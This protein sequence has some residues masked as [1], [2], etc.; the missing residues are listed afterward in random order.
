MKYFQLLFTPTK[1]RRFNELVGFVCFVVAALLFLALATYSPLDPSF[2]T[3]APGPSIRS[4]HNWIGMVGA[5]VSDLLLQFFGIVIFGVPV[6]L[7]M[8][9]IRW[10][11]SREISSPIAKSI[12][13]SLLFVFSSALLSLLPFHWRWLR[14]VAIEGLLGRIVGDFFV[15]YFNTLGAFMLCAT[16]VAIALY[17]STAFSFGTLQLW[18]VIGNASTAEANVQVLRRLSMRPQP[19]SRTSIL[20]VFSPLSRPISAR[21]ALAMPSTIVS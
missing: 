19:A 21:G 8:F 7:T 20:P 16:I 10:W 2:N 6:V 4:P 14:A 3:A 17:L 15:H 9:G 13:A 5:L 11:N 1:N 18:T 12:G